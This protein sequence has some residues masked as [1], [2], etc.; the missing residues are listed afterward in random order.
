METTINKKPHNK[1]YEVF[2][3]AKGFEPLTV[4]LE[5]SV[6]FVSFILILF[7]NSNI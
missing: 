4:C 3:S 6:N 2:V 5:G 7:Q 1:S